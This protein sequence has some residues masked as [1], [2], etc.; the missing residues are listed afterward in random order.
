MPSERLYA[1]L[2]LHSTASDGELEPEAVV[3]LAAERGLAALA[4][5]DHDSVAGVAR[6][7]AR[8]RERGLEVLPGSEMTAYVGRIELHLLAYG[9]PLEADSPLLK[10]LESVRARRRA[11][12]LEMGARLRATSVAVSD[13][14]ILAAGSGAES[15]G[16]VHVGAALVRRGHAPDVSRAIQRFLLAGKPGY[17][18]KMELTPR[19]VLEAVHAAGGVVV[20][21]HPGLAPHD[22]LIPALCREGLDGLEVDYP[23]HNDVN[24]RYYAGWARRYGKLVTGGSDFHGARVHAA[25]YLGSCGVTKGQWSALVRAIERRRC[26]C[27]SRGAAARV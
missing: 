7:V 14:D 4:L 8:G 19:E 5:A 10:L 27:A 16:M 13:E 21:A 24:R 12:A 15:L 26:E 6:A 2:H 25:A 17:V 18:S 20:L 22:E 3:D 9:F 11:R 23:R 1:D